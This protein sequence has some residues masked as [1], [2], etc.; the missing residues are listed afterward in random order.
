[1]LQ[2]TVVLLLA[3]LLHSA[4]AIPGGPMHRGHHSIS[5]RALRLMQQTG[6]VSGDD[7]SNNNTGKAQGTLAQPSVCW[8]VW[9][10]TLRS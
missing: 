3:S 8:G 4:V 9:C 5:H 6:A 7:I 1:M 2:Q 10:T